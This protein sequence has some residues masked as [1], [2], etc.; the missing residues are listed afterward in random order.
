LKD[1]LNTDKNFSDESSAIAYIG[2]KVYFVDGS[3]KAHKLTHKDDFIKTLLFK[4]TI[5]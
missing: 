3:K 2:G 4:E 5:K 1:A